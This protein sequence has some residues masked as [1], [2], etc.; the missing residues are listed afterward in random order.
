MSGKFRKLLIA[1]RG[2]IACRVARTARRLGIRTV[3]VYSDA[4]ADAAHVAP[5]TKP[6][7]SAARCRRTVTCAATSSSRRRAAPAPRPSI[8]ATASSPRTREFARACAAAGVVFIGPSP[9]AIDAMGSKSAAKTL[10]E[11][12]GVPLTPGYHGDRQ[13]PDYLLEQ[14]RAHRLP[15]THQGGGRRRRQGHAPRRRGRRLRRG[16]GQLSARGAGELR[17]RS[18]AGREV[19]EPG[20]AHRSPGVR[21]HARQC[22]L[23]VRARLLGAAS[24]PEGHRGS[25]GARHDAGTARAQMGEAAVA[26]ARAVGLRRRGHRG[27]HRRRRWRVLFHGDEHAPAGRASGDRDDHRSRPGGVAVARRRRRA[28]AAGAGAAADSRARHRGAHLRRGSGA[29]IPALDRQARLSCDARNLRRACASTPA[30]ARAT[31]SRRTTTR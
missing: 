6:C 18:R 13:E 8:P 20:A 24:P 10:M 17:R 21:R 27:I 4:D 23:S 9:E 5:A 16:A 31:R 25:A 19:R 11:K 15:G 14:A 28:A 29:R 30:C 1:N 7:T 26:A 12:A 2:E 22:R 3:A